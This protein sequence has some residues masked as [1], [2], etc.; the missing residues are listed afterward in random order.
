MIRITGVCFMNIY[1]L[2]ISQTVAIRIIALIT[3]TIII[4]I[5]LIRIKHFRA[6]ITYIAKAVSLISFALCLIRIRDQRAVVNAVISAVI[7][8]IRFNGI[9]AIGKFF[10]IGQAIL[11]GIDFV[12]ISSVRQHLVTICQAIIIRVCIKGIRAMDINLI[13]IRQTITISICS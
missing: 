10:S 9:R 5:S 7:I 2:G 11:V 12:G 4:K 1:F 3:Y 8:R 6:V 13:I